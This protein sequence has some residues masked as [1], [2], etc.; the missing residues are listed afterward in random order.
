M[1][2]FYDEILPN[3]MDK[4]DWHARVFRISDTNEPGRKSFVILNQ[5]IDEFI[6]QQFSPPKR[7]YTLFN[8]RY[9]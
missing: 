2:K 8:P 5:D 4:D 1:H 9:V 3:C 7:L 6:K